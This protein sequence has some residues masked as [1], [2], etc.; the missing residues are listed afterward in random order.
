M[1]DYANDTLE[2]EKK[3]VLREIECWRTKIDYLNAEKEHVH[4]LLE[5]S[6]ARYESLITGLLALDKASR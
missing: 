3:V 5:M 1:S 4:G 2:R 6:L